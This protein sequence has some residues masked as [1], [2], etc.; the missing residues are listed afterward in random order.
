VGIPAFGQS[1]REPESA[2]QQKYRHGMEAGLCN[3]GKKPFS[4][5]DDSAR[6]PLRLTDLEERLEIM[7]RQRRWEIIA[8]ERTE[9][10]KK[11]D[12]EN[13]DSLDHIEPREP[14][15]CRC[16]RRDAHGAVRSEERRVGKEC[17]G[18]G[19]AYG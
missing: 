10:V 5:T 2:E 19:V 12:P 3:A 7:F 9:T 18:R 14:R 1:Q 15:A 4:S 6:E 16:G 17:R 11:G 8:G 13:G